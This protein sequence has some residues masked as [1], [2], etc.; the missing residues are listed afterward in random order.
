MG[1]KEA[2]VLAKSV[3]EIYSFKGKK[4]TH[5]KWADKPSEQELIDALLGPTGNLR[6]PCLKV[7]DQLL[8]GFNEESYK[9]IFLQRIPARA[10]SK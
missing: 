10:R 4:V 1:K 8:I 9:S 5:I 2:L 6:A 7:Q 3:S